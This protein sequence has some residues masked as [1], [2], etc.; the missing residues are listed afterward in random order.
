MKPYN[1]DSQTQQDFIALSTCNYGTADS[2]VHN[3]PLPMN[4]FT[5]TLEVTCFLVIPASAASPP[6]PVLFLTVKELS[7]KFRLILWKQSCNKLFTASLK[8]KSILVIT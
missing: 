4:S 3:H 5:K 1:F 2:S 7:Q 8:E 6:N